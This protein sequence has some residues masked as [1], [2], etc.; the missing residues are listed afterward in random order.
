MSLR[1]HMPFEELF[2]EHFR[3]IRPAVG[4]PSLPDQDLIFTL[5]RLVDFGRLGV[6]PTENG[7]LY[8]TSSAAG[9]YFA[10]PASRY[11]SIA[12]IGEDQLADYAAR[13]GKSPDDLR[14]FLQKVL[15]G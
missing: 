7:A 13:R 3:G 14:R 11:F 4:Y 10:H 1:R 6:T 9:F 12:R 8:P 15:E 2:K 5:D